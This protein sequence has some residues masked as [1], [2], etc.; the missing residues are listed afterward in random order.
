MKYQCG[1]LPLPLIHDWYMMTILLSWV[2]K[3]SPLPPKAMPSVQLL[4]IGSRNTWLTCRSPGQ[5]EAVGVVHFGAAW[6]FTR[7][8]LP[9][10]PTAET[11]I[12]SLLQDFCLWLSLPVPSLKL[13]GFLF[14]G[15]WLVLETK[16]NQGTMAQREP[17]PVVTISVPTLLVDDVCYASWLPLNGMN[18]LSD[19]KLPSEL[20]YDPW[21]AEGKC[22]WKTLFLLAVF[23]S[24]KERAGKSTYIYCI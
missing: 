11:F 2:G 23:S 12:L 8:Q 6:P 9:A 5:I 15:R 10:I 16:Q 13:L 14:W 17:L 7:N 3:A 20:H 21:E 1:S 4:R 22:L 19:R 18:G 24:P